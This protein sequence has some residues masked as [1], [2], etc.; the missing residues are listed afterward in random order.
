MK[1]KFCTVSLLSATALLVSASVAHGQRA[2]Q[3]ATAETAAPSTPAEGRGNRGGRGEAAAP[4]A[5]PG[6]SGGIAVTPAAASTNAPATNSTAT[7]TN[8]PAATP[9]AEEP[10]EPVEYDPT[11][12]YPRINIMLRG[13]RNFQR[14]MKLFTSQACVMCHRFGEDAGGIGPDITG[15]GSRFD[16]RELLESIIEPSAIISDIYSAKIYTLTDGKTYSGRQVNET[17]D[18][19]Y[20]SESWTVDPKTRRSFWGENLVTLKRNDIDSVEESKISPMPTGL[21]SLL[22]EDE[23]ADLVGF[24]VSGGNPDDKIFK[25]PPVRPAAPAPTPPSNP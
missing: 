21:V 6:E 11:E 7:S 13:G 14:G 19:I 2:A 22:K 3:P 5:T 9:A 8:T 23:I 10:M 25:L 24:L 1:F 17:A 20:V 12:L 15:A 16:T 4:A 18:E